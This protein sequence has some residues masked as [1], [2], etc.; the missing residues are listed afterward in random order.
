MRL[1]ARKLYEMGHLPRALAEHATWKIPFIRQVRLNM[2]VVDGTPKN[3]I[4]LLRDGHIVIVFPGGVREGLKSSG[5]RY[6]LFWEGHTGFIK[7]AI[8]A[9]VPIVPCFSVGIDHCHHVFANGYQLGKRLFKTYL[10]LPVFIGAG[11]MPF[12]VKLTH[13]VG[14]PIVPNLPR[15]AYRDKRIVALLHKKVLRAEHNLKRRALKE[16]RVWRSSSH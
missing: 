5:E 6:Q 10:P 2:G 13:Y 3:A 11:A 9:D 16:Y 12:P 4:R 1:L 7:V 15:N 14:E 8:A